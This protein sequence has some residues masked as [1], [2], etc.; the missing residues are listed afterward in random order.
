M[1]PPK[2]DAT[3]VSELAQLLRHGTAVDGQIVR[4]LLAVEGDVE[5]RTSLPQGLL[6][7]VGQQLFPGGTLGQMGQLSIEL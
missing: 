7:Q 6:R 3:L 1:V 4:Q 5:F 2:P